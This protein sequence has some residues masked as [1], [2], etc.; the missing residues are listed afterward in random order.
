MFWVVWITCNLDDE[1]S[2]IFC[3]KEHCQTSF[4]LIA[5]P[6]LMARNAPNIYPTRRHTIACAAAIFEIPN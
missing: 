2:T 6:V 3:A 5:S 4:P 1:V